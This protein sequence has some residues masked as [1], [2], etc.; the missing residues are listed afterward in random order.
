M[1]VDSLGIE[2]LEPSS[3]LSIA[4]GAVLLE[5]IERAEQGA[6]LC[7]SVRSGAVPVGRSVAI[8]GIAWRDYFFIS[9]DDAHL[10]HNLASVANLEIVISWVSTSNHMQEAKRKLP[11]NRIIAKLETRISPNALINILRHSQSVLIGRSDLAAEVGDELDSLTRRYVQ[12]AKAA[13]IEV[14]VGSV[15]FDSLES[16]ERP[17]ASE[18][19][20]A[21]WF[22]ENGVSA[23]LIGGSGAP[24]PL[25][26]K[27][28]AI[29]ELFR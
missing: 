17:S 27:F 26:R 13:N 16:A 12:S 4:D 7:K 10:G 21:I 3:I 5:V 18:I 14:A 22:L 29:R 9:S 11:G 6:V 20:N 23:L 28:L 1:Q 19:G 25:L 24:A 2:S 8:A 15:L